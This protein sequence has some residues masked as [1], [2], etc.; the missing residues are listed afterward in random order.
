MRIVT[1]HHL[2]WWAETTPLD[3]RAETAELI[4]SLIRASCPGLDYYRFPVGNAS[5]THGLDGVTEVTKGTAFVPEGRTIWEIGAGADYKAKAD[6]EYA[7]RTGQLSPEERQRTNFIFAT[8][9][10]W[11]TGREAWE[12]EHT[13]EGWL[14]VKAYDAV[15]LENWLADQ[16]AVAISFAKGLQILPPAGFQTIQDFWEEHSLS[17][18]PPLAEDLLLTGRAERAKRLCESLSAGIRGI[19]RWQADSA[20][21]AALFVAAALR[22][23]DAELSQFF[24]SKTLLIESV[25]AARQLPPSGGFI[26]ILFPENHRLGPA[27]ERA[28]QVILALGS[29]NIAASLV[30][31][32]D[33]MSTQDFAAGL[34]AMGIEEHE[35]FRLAGIC[36]RSVTVFSRLNARGTVVPPSWSGDP[37]LV[38]LALAGGWDASNE[39]DRAVI[40]ALCDMPYDQVDLNA[41]RLASQADAPLD[42]DG[43]IW[44]I[45]SQKDA[46]T[47]LGAQIGDAH[48]GR[49]RT[50]CIA[51][52]SE[53][54]RT[55]DVPDEDQPAIPTRGADFRHS[56]W[57]RRGLSR[58]LLLISGLHQAARF[59]T[60][61]LT[62][63]Q[64][65]DDVVGR[66]RDLSV[67][68]R[69][70]ASLKSEF[71]TLMEAAPL[72]LASA[73][74]QVLE[75]DS[76]KWAPV[77]FRGKEGSPLFGRTSP[78]TYVLWAL[79]TL[80][81]NPAYLYTA[82]SMLLRLAEADPGGATSNRP[83]DSLRRIFLA[84]RPQTNAPLA[85][86][87]AIVRRIC[88]A[89]P[90][91]GFKF[92]LALLPVSHDSTHDTAKPRLRDF[93]D[94]AKT[95]TT[96]G[97]MAAAFSAY[98]SLAVELADSHA[99]R[100]MALIDGFAGLDP[101]A[102]ERA[103]NSIRSVAA[104]MNA[105][106]R[107]EMWTKLRLF[108]QR[109]RG[110][111]KTD[112][113]LRDDQLRPLEIL[114]EELAPEDPVHRDL[115]Q[116]N[117][118]VP[119]MEMR[120]GGDYVEE[121][122]RSRREVV[123]GILIDR[124]ISAVIAL[125]KAAKEPHLVGYAL[126]EAAE[127]Q[128]ALEEVFRTHFSAKSE[129]DEDFFVAVSGAAHF[130]FGATWDRW[131]ADVA[132]NSGP[133][134]GA[135]LFL[136][137]PDNRG[138]WSFVRDLGPSI[139][140]EYWR[141]KY[142]L[143][144]SSDEDL[145]FAIEKYNSV[146]RFSASVDLIAYQEK[147]VPSEVCIA[148]LRGLVGEL[149]ASGRNTQGTIYSA[150]HL[151]A[152]LQG[153]ED[154]SI[155][156]LALLE[157]Q[158]LPILGH[159]G[160]PVALVQLL[161]SS[162]KFFVGV[163]C[164][165]FFPASQKERGEISEERRAKAR[166]GYQMLQSMKS[167]PGFT[168]SGHDEDALR[169]WIAEAR[170]LS[171]EADRATIA[172]QQ[173][174][175]MLAHAPL[176]AEDGAWPARPVRK[177]IEENA[178]DEIERGIAIAR[179]N[180]RGPFV[181]PLYEGGKEER[182]LAAQYREW[183]HAAARWPRTSRLLRQ[184]AE[185]WERHAEQAD[186]RAELDQRLDT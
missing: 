116:F 30:E 10:I 129:I 34:R 76:K 178:S 131:V 155:E 153:R 57:V 14:S 73:L 157:Y 181:K 169:S 68:I 171:K 143:N 120:A 117:D 63:E 67:N 145:L 108:A 102:R 4:R 2:K 45:R 136:R 158:Y 134:R 8:P 114:C 112:W 91:V 78:H 32:L 104:A 113:A 9:R 94:A 24:L 176:D 141:K 19:S 172:D 43:S 21:E 54:D 173:I 115:W 72:P 26:L 85:E 20:N 41:R 35:A 101:E 62:P 13:R 152:D 159:E 166:L 103:I 139:E 5:Q 140:Q 17:T 174:G 167:L 51:V 162:P 16:P 18:T 33:Q 142:A 39:H 69:V 70:L 15:T 105:E 36:C 71:P 132:T 185:D 37:A 27:L 138:T 106:D 125:A 146:G 154:V 156:E 119:K 44:T 184:I 40:A 95:S 38:P 29:D 90:E 96:R 123:R 135:T 148:A 61:G 99:G 47:L 128:A 107:Y 86:R 53:I 22:R 149:N 144:Q 98:A 124:G 170:A 133:R 46:F 87:I 75:G 7:K 25:E 180:M 160:E 183:G 77:I 1:A 168:E 6:E 83:M 163:I 81:W 50:A 12:S 82:S 79:E 110:F 58:T 56:E 121:S 122:N 64:F 42:L 55:L 130:R 97:E 126:A 150:T 80:A 60:I 137:W 92:A 127:S 3:A 48:Q 182:A 177:V 74:E 23:A 164:D 161:K 89:R 49:L 52:F 59:R 179:F 111:Q 84:W 109:H 11:D 118:L 147:R 165:A 186:V 65:V 151:I 88:T 66:L 31:Q 93:G 28:N 175:Q 100:L